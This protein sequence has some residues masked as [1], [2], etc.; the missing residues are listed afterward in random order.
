MEIL[1]NLPFNN[2]LKDMNCELEWSIGII[3]WKWIR[4]RSEGL[5]Y[6]DIWYSAKT[7]RPTMYRVSFSF[8]YSVELDFSICHLVPPE[9]WVLGGKEWPARESNPPLE[10]LPPRISLSRLFPPNAMH[11]NWG[12]DSGGLSS[13]LS[14][15]PFQGREEGAAELSL[16]FP[17]PVEHKRTQLHFRIPP[18]QTRH[19]F[20]PKCP[21][22]FSNFKGSNSLDFLLLSSALDFNYRPINGTLQI[23]CSSVHVIR[24]CKKLWYS[25][26]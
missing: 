2:E 6:M 14:L 26:S 7:C 17:S 21:Y 24:N 9:K 13:S 10:S 20:N 1:F 12:D 8:S 18:M 15:L 5:C 4:I 19:L 23:V 16:R 11:G 3:I 22:N 25:N